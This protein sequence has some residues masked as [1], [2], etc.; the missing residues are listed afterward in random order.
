M[1]YLYMCLSLHQELLSFKHPHMV[2]PRLQLERPDQTVQRVFDPPW[3]D[4]VSA[5]LR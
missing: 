2:N 5:H 4:I 1:L 3:D